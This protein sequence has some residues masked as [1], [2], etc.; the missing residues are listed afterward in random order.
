VKDEKSVAVEVINL[1]F[2]IE[3]CLLED[4]NTLCC[5]NEEGN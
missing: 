2:Y 4:K 1:G 3:L 5:P